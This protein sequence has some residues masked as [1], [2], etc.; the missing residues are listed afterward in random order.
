MKKSLIALGVLAAVVGVAQ[1]ENQTTLYGSMAHSVVVADDAG[2][3]KT[4]WISE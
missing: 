2:I 4:V 3:D 1:A